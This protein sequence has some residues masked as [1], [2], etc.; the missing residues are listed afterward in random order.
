[1]YSS[2][3]SGITCSH[4]F[5]LIYACDSAILLIILKRATLKIISLTN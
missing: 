4:F 5:P 1:M 2:S 3:M